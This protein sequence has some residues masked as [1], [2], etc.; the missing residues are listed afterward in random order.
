MKLLVILAT[1]F[2]V[3]LAQER[4]VVREPRCPTNEDPFNPTHLAHPSDCK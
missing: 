2:A 3:A 1:L 4:L